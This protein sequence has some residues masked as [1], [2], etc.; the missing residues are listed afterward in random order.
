M[1]QIPVLPGDI[2][3]KGDTYTYGFS[4]GK[5]AFDISADGSVVVGGMIAESGLE[6]AFMWQVGDDENRGLGEL[7]GGQIIKQGLRQ[8]EVDQTCIDQD[9]SHSGSE[10][11]FQNSLSLITDIN[12]A[13]LSEVNAIGEFE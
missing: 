8:V 1:E 2:D 10:P 11:D 3:S 12:P 5:G 13:I 9:I 7:P 4:P 6:E